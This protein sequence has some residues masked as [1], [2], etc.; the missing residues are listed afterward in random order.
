MALNK[1]NIQTT[2]EVINNSNIRDM[3][4]HLKRSLTRAVHLP[5]QITSTSKM[6]GKIKPVSVLMPPMLTEVTWIV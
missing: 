1:K 2:N 6:L 5:E 3:S 4:G